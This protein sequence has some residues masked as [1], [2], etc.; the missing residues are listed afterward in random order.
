MANQKECIVPSSNYPTIQSAINDTSVE[1]IKVNAGKYSENL[2]IKRSLKLNG[3]SADT[4]I[5]DGKRSGTVITIS[6]Q[7]SVTISGFTITGGD[8][9]KNNGQGGGICIRKAAE[10]TIC[11]NNIS[12][13]Y[14]SSEV[15]TF[16]WG[17][18]IYAE[19]T[20][21]P[22]TIE[23]NVIQNNIAFS[24]PMTSNVIEDK[25]SGNGGG[26]AIGK[27]VT[28]N[29]KNNTVRGNI[30]FTR[31]DDTGFPYLGK[32]WGGGGIYT[33]GNVTNIEGNTI[34]DNIGG[35]RG[36][37][38][39]G[40]GIN[41]TS[42]DVTIHNNT[43]RNNTAVI[44]GS[45]GQGGGINATAQLHK[46]VVTK[47][48][49]EGN[50]G[51]I[52]GHS[53]LPNAFISCGGGGLHIFGRVGP[54]DNSITVKE[55][56][57]KGNIVAQ[58]IIGS[59]G[60]GAV[61][62]GGGGAIY[63]ARCNDVLIDSNSIIGNTG[64]ENVQ[65]SGSGAFGGSQGGGLVIQ[66]CNKVL[67][68]KN[69]VKDNV[70]SKKL[71]NVGAISSNDGGGISI[72]RSPDATIT[73][74]IIS[75]NKCV[76][77]ASYISN[78]ALGMHLVRGGGLYVND[79]EL[80][81]F[82]GP[83]NYQDKVVIK[84]N[85][86]VNNT[87]ADI[88][89]E[90]GGASKSMIMGGGIFVGNITSVE[91][92]ENEVNDNTNAVTQTPNIFSIMPDIAV[93]KNGQMQ[94]ENNNVKNN[95]Y[96]RTA[97]EWQVREVEMIPQVYKFKVGNFNCVAVGD[98]CLPYMQPS[99]FLFCNAPQEE[100]E[101]AM[102]A[103]NFPNQ[104]WVGTYTC[105]FIDT[106][107]NKVLLDT[108]PGM[109]SPSTNQLIPNLMAAGIKPEDI[110]TI[111]ITHAHP[112]HIG[113]NVDSEGKIKFPNARFMMWKEE[114]D[115]WTK[116]PDLSKLPWPDFFKMNLLIFNGSQLPLISEKMVVIE[117]PGE[118]LPGISLI[119]AQGHTPGHVIIK[120]TSEKESVAYISDLI[121]HPIHCEHPDWFSML[122][123]NFELTYTSRLK[124]LEQLANEGTP[125]IGFHF[126]FPGMG[127]VVK[128]GKV[129]SWEKIN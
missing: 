102:T 61:I 73:N 54:A 10:V 97:K 77:S 75:G 88:L 25:G 48:T 90:Q 17:G 27:G 2:V 44:D 116:N 15:N 82:D 64:V 63:V 69:E 60:Q 51:I 49:V 99:G 43:I 76:E 30:G 31:G 125:A 28:S 34:I 52:Q 117:K 65:L 124:V 36:N 72:W 101:K 93:Y 45:F 114:W 46:I 127:K 57:F 66:A 122:D 84:G 115:F 121:L 74:N 81:D 85:T 108:G 9:S 80:P 118:I 68:N 24:V 35:L 95:N 42:G 103:Y 123:M 91:I 58:S 89:S 106:G 110:D 120:V 86:I 26:I 92:K 53:P 8:A 111:I 39:N 6:D 3:A 40:G 98:G 32:T 107:K 119:P 70:I 113:G 87:G 37:V 128:K 12:D 23:N 33:G 20:S 109:C 29:I 4:T 105:L 16:G 1:V 47:N 19:E 67:I 59:G 41:I 14:A 13:N 56:I 7:A 129:W 11:N 79:V 112:D 21:K 104:L 71:I 55:N 22:L 126:D 18:G 100:L 83:P 62:G 96:Y 50:T 38:G 78:D 94:I 5:I